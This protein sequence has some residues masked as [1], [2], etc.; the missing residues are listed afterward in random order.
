MFIWLPIC[1]KKWFG[2]FSLFISH[3]G[4]ASSSLSSSS[5]SSLL[6]LVTHSRH[7][8]IHSSRTCAPT[9]APLNYGWRLN[10]ID[11]DV[12]RQPCAIYVLHPVT[13]AEP[14]QPRSSPGCTE[15]TV[16]PWLQRHNAV[17]PHTQNRPRKWGCLQHVQ[18]NNIILTPQIFC[19]PPSKTLHPQ[20]HPPC[21]PSLFS[22]LFNVCFSVAPRSAVA[23]LHTHPLKGM[24]WWAYI[25]KWF[26]LVHY[27]HKIK[28]DS[29]G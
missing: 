3:Q 17:A 21:W 6:M 16:S 29:S 7:D 13:T 15:I 8:D 24:L 10:S 14:K 5:S 9:C 1:R 20:P 18:I 2:P 25:T 27:M 26:L 22:K 11:E 4:P 19:Y 12:M 28:P 23:S